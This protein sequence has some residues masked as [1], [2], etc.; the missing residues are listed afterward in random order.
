MPAVVI[1][2]LVVALVHG[3]AH[4]G[5]RVPLSTTGNLF[6]FIVI[7]AGPLVGLA[8]TRASV[9]AGT[10]LVAAT[11]AASLLFGLI[12]HFIVSSPDHVARVDPQWAI[13]FGTTAILLAITEA[14]GCGLAIALLRERTVRA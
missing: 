4:N 2:H 10:S 8:L 14:L 9:R 6:V 1:G 12:N 7:L 13:L 5:A 11:L 3:A